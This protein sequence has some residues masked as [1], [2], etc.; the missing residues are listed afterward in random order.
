MTIHLFSSVP[1]GGDRDKFPL[2]PDGYLW[3]NESIYVSDGSM[4][5]DSPSVN[6]QGAIM[7]IARM[8][9]IKFLTKMG[10]NEV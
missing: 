6:P 5:C 8:N 10:F 3:D 7:A 4:L 9:A 2:S 1:M